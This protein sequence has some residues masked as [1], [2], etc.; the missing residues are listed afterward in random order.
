[1]RQKSDQRN[2]GLQNT[3]T[4][5]DPTLIRVISVYVVSRYRHS[6]TPG[7]QLYHVCSMEECEALCTRLAIMVN[8]QFKCLGS[9]QHLKNKYEN[10]FHVVCYILT[11]P[12]QTLLPLSFRYGSGFSLQAKMGPKQKVL[13]CPSDQQ[14]TAFSAASPLATLPAASSDPDFENSPTERFP[15]VAACALPL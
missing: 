1:M 13:N 8:G 9:V 14:E 2:Y 5:L 4:Q 10:P 11:S 6:L 7:V 12:I 15:P 3:I